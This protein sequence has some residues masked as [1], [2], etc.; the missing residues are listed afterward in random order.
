[1]VINNFIT[2]S[3][4]CVTSLQVKTDM[5]EA[6]GPATSRF[7]RREAR[8]VSLVCQMVKMNEEYTLL[9]VGWISEHEDLSEQRFKVSLP[10]YLER[11]SRI[12]G[13]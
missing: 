13:V 10:A 8:R 11:I 2:E 6:T 12:S 3:I 7:K 9:T 5:R 4:R 1:M